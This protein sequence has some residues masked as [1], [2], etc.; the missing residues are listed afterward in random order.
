M[1]NENELT[2]ALIPKYELITSKTL[3]NKELKYSR[4]VMYKHEDVNAEVR[5]D[6]MDEDISSIWISIGLKHQKKILVGGL[7]REWQLLGADN[8]EASGSIS[9]QLSR[10]NKFLEQW[11]KAINEDKEVVLIGD[12]NLDWLTCLNA[13]PPP[14][15]QAYK[16]KPPVEQLVM[17]VFS[18]G[19]CQL[20]TEVTRS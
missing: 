14:N 12:A 4:V 7:Y 17:K 9:S 15:C 11:I 19:V 2:N 20:V 16:T 10:W 6:L 3:Q 8:D 1:L 5:L 13:D 18:L